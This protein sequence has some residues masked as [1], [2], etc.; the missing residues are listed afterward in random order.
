MSIRT[1]VALAAAALSAAALSACVVAPAQPYPYGYSA[2]AGS[3]V[4]ADVAPPAPYYEPV[5]VAP[6]PGAVWIT[7]YWGWSGG[8]HVWVGGHYERARPGYT[9]QPHRWAH[10]G[11]GRWHLEEGHWAHR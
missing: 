6:Y 3:V 1:T 5:P 8:R 2:A 10:R 11:D 7:G 9:W 4:V